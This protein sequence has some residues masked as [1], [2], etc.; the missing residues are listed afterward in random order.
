MP[1]AVPGQPRAAP[2]E[3]CRDRLILHRREPVSPLDSQLNVSPAAMELLPLTRRLAERV[4]ICRRPSSVFKGSVTQ[5]LV[6]LPHL[7]PQGEKTTE[8]QTRGEAA[9]ATKALGGRAGVSPARTAPAKLS[10][11]VTRSE[12][13]SSSVEGS[14]GNEVDLRFL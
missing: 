14:G 2:L 9:D 13:L 7:R 8:P 11:P 4:V 10:Q 6:A 5:D 1:R 3:P 12:L